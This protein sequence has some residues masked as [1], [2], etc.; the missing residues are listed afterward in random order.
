M[1]VGG[2]PSSRPMRWR[3]A[4]WLAAATL[5][6]VNFLRRG[7]DAFDIVLAAVV[8]AF[9]FAIEHVETQT[10]RPRKTFLRGALVS[11]ALALALVGMPLTMGSSLWLGLTLWIAMSG[12]TIF[13]CF[14][15]E[16]TDPL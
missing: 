14:Y 2:S 10:R 9:G 6:L 7:F 16:R 12:A 1:T 8:V 3:N 5:F 11:L 4:V 13:W 15:Y